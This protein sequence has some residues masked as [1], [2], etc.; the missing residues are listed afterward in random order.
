MD[1]VFKVLCLECCVGDHPVSKVKKQG[2]FLNSCSRHPRVRSGISRLPRV[3]LSQTATGHHLVACSSVPVCHGWGQRVWLCSKAV[4]CSGV[5]LTG[6]KPCKADGNRT[7]CCDSTRI[8]YIWNDLCNSNKSNSYLT[9]HRKFPVLEDF[10]HLW[11]HHPKTLLTFF[12][13]LWLECNC[14]IRSCCFLLY[15]A[16]AKCIPIS[17][18][19]RTS[20]PPL[21]SPTLPSTSSQSTQRS[22][23]CCTA[24]SC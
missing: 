10:E 22:S 11:R 5:R 21:P 9:K 24:A 3:P 19:S 13:N 16:A 20:F 23:W 14:F 8:N 7:V 2:S 17:P 12:K 6:T 18:P 4:F 15:E 1:A